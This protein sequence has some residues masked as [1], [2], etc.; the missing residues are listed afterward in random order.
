MMSYADE[1][2]NKLSNNTGTIKAVI[3]ARVS[4]D[5]DAQKDSC[6][7]Q[8]A[9][10]QNFISR[11]PNIV[12]L[13]TYVDDGISGKNDFNRPQYNE[14]LHKLRT[15][16]FDLIISKS[17]SRLN[18][19][20]VNSQALQ[21]IL[22]DANA[23]IFTLEDS[24]V[25]DFDDM[26]SGL[27]HSLKYAIDAMY[28][29]QQSINGRKTH[30]LRVL[31]R[32]LSA[33]D[34]SF[35]YVWH[36]DTRTIL[37]NEEEAQIICWIFDEYVFHNA[38]PASI[39]KALIA[40]GITM[41]ERNVINILRNERYIGKFYINKRTTKLGTG[42]K[43]SRRILLPKDQ[44]VLCERP[45]LKIVDPEIF[46]LAQKINAKRADW[47]STIDEE[48]VQA[49]FQGRHTFSHII[50]CSECG[51]PYLHQY[52]ESK[53]RIPIYRLR[54]HS[55]C[56]NK[57]LRLNEKDI[58]EITKTALRHCI[59]QQD[60]VC[61][62][63]ERILTECVKE[64]K[65]ASPENIGKLKKQ[66]ATRESQ[67]D[68]LINALAEGGLTD[69][70]KD[71]IKGKINTIMNEISDLEKQISFQESSATEDSQRTKKLIAKIKDSIEE[72]KKFNEIDR[73]RVINYL[74]RIVVHPNGNIDITLKS[75]QQITTSIDSGSESDL[76]QDILSGKFG[77]QDAQYS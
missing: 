61:A 23:T 20:E 8:V 53:D 32:E 33:K 66:K 46:A 4:T 22:Q 65:D 26:N 19:D 3:Y 67:I 55:D 7:N 11:H 31:R 41:C 50:F 54:K 5:N 13:G 77:I 28:V 14:M 27:L 75:G 59:K 47:F 42:Q 34:V 57:I 29:K 71:R 9:L 38:T 69:V 60:A 37:V 39:H 12:L 56:R 63:L 70:S 40:K 15:D 74:E 30:E 25:H 24:Q 73:D 10:A 64:S 36:K 72:L 58:S 18:R 48:S 52:T 49:R 6:E 51:K 62:S 68:S 21:V 2:K 16:H 17:L 45:E 35:G 1:I 44:W 76:T 43:K